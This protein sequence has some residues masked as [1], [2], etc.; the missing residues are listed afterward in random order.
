MRMLSNQSNNI[1]PPVTKPPDQ[2]KVI[3]PKPVVI[4]VTPPLM[5]KVIRAINHFIQHLLKVHL[6]TEGVLLVILWD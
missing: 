5:Y 3:M 1:K 6:D 4:H 2:A